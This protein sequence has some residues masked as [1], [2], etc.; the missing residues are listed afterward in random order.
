VHPCVSDG[1]LVWSTG[2]HAWFGVFRISIVFAASRRAPVAAMCA[3]PP[4][5]LIVLFVRFPLSKAIPDRPNFVKAS[6]G[7][8]LINFLGKHGLTIESGPK[9]SV[10]LAATYVDD[11]V[12]KHDAKG[13]SSRI[14]HWC[15]LTAPLL[16][17]LVPQASTCSDLD[18]LLLLL[19]QLFVLLRIMFLSQK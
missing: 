4:A 5:C 18:L 3:H 15:L 12:S 11:R 13:S 14:L 10:N 6:F 2:R 17:A 9:S 8:P 7:P 1:H 19:L 16:F